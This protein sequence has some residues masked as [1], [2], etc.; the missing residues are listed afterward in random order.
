Q[1]VIFGLL[2]GFYLITNHAWRMFGPARSKAARSG[3]S[4]GVT[5]ILQTSL[6]YLA[7]VVADVLFRGTSA[8]NA[9]AGVCGMLGFGVGGTDSAWTNRNLLSLALCGVIAF[10]APNIYQLMR[11]YP[12][13]LGKIKP[14]GDLIPRWQ[15]SR[16]WAIGMGIVAAFAIANLWNV[17]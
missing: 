12:V 16:R 2:H 4:S 15:P 9:A 11:S 6:T 10:S 5:A 14:V 3:L 17:T 13:A 8:T 1:F 7:V